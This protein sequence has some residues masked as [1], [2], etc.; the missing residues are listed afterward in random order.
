MLK[1]ITFRAL[2]YIMIESI[3]LLTNGITMKYSN[4][5]IGSVICLIGFSTSVYPANP[6]SIEYVDLK[7][8]NLQTQINDIKPGTTYIAGTGISIAGNII[9]N[10][11]PGITYT[12]GTGIGITGNVITNNS[13]GIT[14]TGGN[15]INISGTTI[16]A[17]T[18]VA[19]FIRTIQSP[20]NSVPPGTA[21]TIDTQVF[22]NI[23]ASVV[24]AA[25][26][27]GTVFTLS[28]GSYVIDY[29]MSL[30]AAGSI[31][32]YIGPN[33][34]SLSLDTNTVSGSSTGTTWI[35]GRSI[36][37]FNLPTVLAIS[38]VVGTASVATTGTDAGSYMVRLTI[39]KIA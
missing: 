32:L 21:F 20:N 1:T 36:E 18:G 23:P 30:A 31:G 15:G 9:S 37:L 39:L 35:H 13:P 28:S 3:G 17:T 14:Y 24:A 34:G 22:N 12:A 7:F 16:S 29:E 27:G 38:S 4:E 33:A 5:L 8:Q 6:A 25:G 26:D 10:S 19:E 2:S 11:N